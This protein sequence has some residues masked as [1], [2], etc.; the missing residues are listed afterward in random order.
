M[1]I[2]RIP[3][4]V[5]LSRLAYYDRDTTRRVALQKLFS[6]MGDISRR[7]NL[8]ACA[9]C[10]RLAAL[11]T[12]GVCGKIRVAYAVEAGATSQYS[13][14][15]R[16]RLPPTSLPVCHRRLRPWTFCLSDAAIPRLLP[17]RLSRE[18]DVHIGVLIGRGFSWMWVVN[19]RTQSLGAR[20]PARALRAAGKFGPPEYYA[21]LMRG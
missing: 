19:F 15:R 8:W 18:D 10:G 4:L 11:P 2:G 17:P 5:G 9:K 3:N 20:R 7:Y 1:V 14:L 13:S 6:P 21:P 16:V 12:S